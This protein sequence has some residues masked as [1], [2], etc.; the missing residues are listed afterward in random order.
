VGK[1][2]E[3]TIRRTQT[4]DVKNT[5]GELGRARAKNT[6]LAQGPLVVNNHSSTWVLNGGFVVG[7]DGGFYLNSTSSANCGGNGKT[8]LALSVWGFLASC[9]YGT[10]KYESP[11]GLWSHARGAGN[12]EIVGVTGSRDAGHETKKVSI[13]NAKSGLTE[14]KWGFSFNSIWKANRGMPR[15]SRR[16]ALSHRK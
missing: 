8:R 6:S 3:G 7:L 2:V 5:E 12:N 11:S 10:D 14:K 15:R 1:T 9:F 16:L 4:T 13:L